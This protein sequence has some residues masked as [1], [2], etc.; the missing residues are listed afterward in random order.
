MIFKAYAQATG[1]DA[2]KVKWISADNAALPALLATGKVDAIGQF[3]VG[4]PLLAAAVAPKALVRLAYKDA[5]LDYYAE[6]NRRHRGDDPKI[7]QMY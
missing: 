2:Q 5:G 3:T 4:Q 1:V 6:R 7:I